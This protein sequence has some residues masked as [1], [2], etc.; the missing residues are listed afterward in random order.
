MWGCVNNTKVLEERGRDEGI[1]RR[2]QNVRNED[3]ATGE[4][5]GD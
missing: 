1:F 4:L 2:R 3:E 5:T